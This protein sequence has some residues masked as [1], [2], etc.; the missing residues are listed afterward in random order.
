MGAEWS[1]SLSDT[2]IEFQYIYLIKHVLVLYFIEGEEL[3][4]GTSTP[5][6][7]VS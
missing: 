6:P 2:E 1:S 4:S 3:A 7:I 5:T